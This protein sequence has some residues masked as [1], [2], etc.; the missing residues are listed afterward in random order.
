M[1]AEPNAQEKTILEKEEEETDSKEINKELQKESEKTKKEEKETL[2]SI[3]EKVDKTL[4]KGF[5]K[6]FSRFRK[7]LESDKRLKNQLMKFSN[8][9][10]LLCKAFSRKSKAKILKGEK[11]F[12]KIMA[13]HETIRLLIPNKKFC[14]ASLEWWKLA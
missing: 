3:L 1:S 12:A 5:Q 11:R 8:L 14:P 6:K 4:S 9:E 7:H 10:P 2:A 13:R